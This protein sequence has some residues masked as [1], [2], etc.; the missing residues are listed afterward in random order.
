[1]KI[2]SGAFAAVPA[3]LCAVGCTQSEA[4]RPLPAPP[5]VVDFSADV[6][7][8]NPGESAT[9]TFDVT[10]ADEVTIV[11][12]TGGKIAYDGDATH[13]TAVVSPLETAFYVLRARGAGGRAN[14]FVQLAVGEDLREVFLVAVPPVIDSGEHAQLLWSAFHAQ[15]A[16]LRDSRGGV[17]PLDVSGGAGVVDVAPARTTGYSLVATGANP[18]TVLEQHADIQVRPVVASFDATPAAAKVGETI[19]L[20]WKT[21]GAE[22]VVITEKTFGQLYKATLPTDENAVDQGT[23]AWTVPAERPDQQAVTD[24]FPLEFTLTVK[25]T[26]PMMTLTR[27]VSGFVGE[28]PRITSFVI[29]A[30]VTTGHTFE[31]AWKTVNAERLQVL[32]DGGLLYEPLPRD[33]AKVAE[34]RLTLAAPKA[35]TTFTLIAWGHEGVRAESSSVVRIVAPPT[36]DEFNLPASINAAG[37]PANATW[38][39]TNATRVVVRLENGPTLFTTDDPARVASGNENIFPGNKSVFVLEAFNDAG[40]RVTAKQTVD[41]LS[42]PGLITATPTPVTPGE[43]ISVSWLLD[44]TVSPSVIGD[45]TQPAIVNNPAGDWY[46]LDEH[47]D[48]RAL[49]FDDPDDGT[50]TL[51]APAGFRFPFVGL[52]ETEFHVSTNGFISFEDVGALPDNVTLDDPDDGAPALVAPFWDDLTLGENGRV[53]YLWEGTSFPRRLIV[54]WDKVHVTADEQGSELTFEV[55]LWETGEIHFAYKTLNGTDSAGEGATVGWKRSDSLYEKRGEPNTAVLTPGDEFIF[56]ASGSS[57]GAFEITADH[58]SDFVLFARRPVGNGYVV[59]SARASVIPPGSVLVNEL[60]VRP[61][62]ATP[63]GRWLELHN[64]TDEEFDISGALLESAATMT[65][66]ALPEGTVI[67]PNGYLVIGD[68]AD[69]AQNGGANVTVEWSGF[70]PADTADETITLSAVGEISHLDYAAADVQEAVSIQ[71]PDLSAIDTNGNGLVCT[72]RSMTYGSDGAIGT[73]GAKN[74]SC[75]EYE[76]STIPVAFE[77]ISATGTPLFEQ[78]VDDQTASV[79]VGS[80]PI[81]YFKTPVSTISVCTNGWIALSS[82][83]LSSYSNATKPSSSAPTALAALFWDDLEV[84][85]TPES[86]VF[87]QRLEAGAGL[88]GRWIVQY[89]AVTNHNAPDTLEM[90]AKFFDDGVIEYHYADMVSG[91]SSNLADGHSATIWLERLNGSAAM[92]IGINQPVITSNTAYRFT[93]RP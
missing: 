69:P 27:M 22:E 64:T 42:A 73:P 30:A 61:S 68:S 7:R 89:H 76:L 62:P 34:G 21:G 78:E 10:G 16:E 80:N 19:Q 5:V 93:P 37:N 15:S 75:F 50:A 90:E 74:E 31:V 32:A 17:T 58:S 6:T 44:D 54:Q 86:N 70:T 46:E 25:Q 14:A 29:P 9:L 35:D 45:P 65:S 20:S 82:T 83:T 53:L 56:M 66:F 88:P 24:G 52:Q 55:Q 36:I 11:D 38:K 33:T 92:P 43:T 28:G 87:V 71:G 3:L 4:P 39:T 85:D 47:V 26:D 91:S 81:T 84:G 48:A 8:I 40:E 63:A 67:A 77:D 49:Q 12:Q 41:V 79:D 2:S 60:M 59:Y 13:G 23:F 51:Q 18:E 72:Q 57:T 1:M